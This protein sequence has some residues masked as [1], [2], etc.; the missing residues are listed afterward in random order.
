[1]LRSNCI[2]G[3]PIGPMPLPPAFW[4]S[5]GNRSCA[6]VVRVPD[7]RLGDRRQPAQ[8]GVVARVVDRR[9]AVE[10]LAGLLGVRREVVV[11]VRLVRSHAERPAVV[12]RPADEHP[13]ADALGPARRIRVLGVRRVVAEVDVPVGA[14][15][16]EPERIAHAHRRRSRAGSAPGRAEQVALRDRVVLPA[17]AHAGC[18]G[19]CRAG[20]S[21]CPTS[22]G[23]RTR[24]CASRDRRSACSPPTGTGSCRRPST[25][26]GCPAPSKS[27]WPPTWQQMPRDIGTRRISCSLENVS[28]PL[29]NLNRD[30]RLYP[31][32]CARR[33]RSLA[34]VRVS[35]ASPSLMP[36]PTTSLGVSS[37]GE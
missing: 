30:N 34:D 11:D 31:L 36:V 37:R 9:E 23:R 19:S 25:G 10:L 8:A 24:D 29:S 6:R 21:Y 15:D 26:R 32:N 1:M 35:G 13:A 3:P 20:R 12:G 17:V 27:I 28:R 33:A 2:A 14:V 16:R 5:S 7:V 4:N 22:A 18:A